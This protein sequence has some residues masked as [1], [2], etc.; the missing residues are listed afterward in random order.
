MENYLNFV[1]IIN[2]NIFLSYIKFSK[3]INILNDVINTSLVM[4]R[5]GRS[6]RPGSTV[7]PTPEGLRKSPLWLVT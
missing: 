4:S 6:A 2:R 3:V 1:M 5:A 7:T